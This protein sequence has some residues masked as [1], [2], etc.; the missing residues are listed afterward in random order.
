M[1]IV[2][3]E[4]HTGPRDRRWIRRDRLAGDA[5]SRRYTRAW[6]DSSRSFIL[7]E[8][9]G[10][11]L[12]HM[13]RDLEVAGWLRDRGIRVPAVMAHDLT[14]GWMVVEDL[15]TDDAEAVLRRTPD[16]ERLAV[17]QAALRP[18]QVLAAQPVSSL[19]AWNPPLDR[20]R[21]RWELTGFEL[22]FLRHHRSAPPSAK[23]ERW[24]DGL[25]ESVAEHPRRVCHRDYHLN[26]LFFVG[27]GETAVIDAQDALI[28]PDTYDAV[29]LVEERAMP[30]LLG[31]LGLESLRTAWADRTR[32][33][34]G[35]RE[36]WSRVRL[37][38][39]LKVLGTFAR[40]VA[41]GRAHY[42]P[43]MAHQAAGIAADR[44]PLELP[45]ELVDLL[46]D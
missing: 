16:L 26:N 19:P 37:Q 15:G 34:D 45:S 36:R 8:Y 3:L 10:E 17:S 46:L 27:G 44:E 25:A 11:A 35:W 9:P 24:L 13:R 6:D 41:S 7:V 32:A 39:S 14:A 42:G 29:S 5:S 1:T 33:A 40:L 4:T 21:L 30:E 38:R 20:R 31:G 43:W 2:T 28:G 23:L 22:W 18:L 12:G